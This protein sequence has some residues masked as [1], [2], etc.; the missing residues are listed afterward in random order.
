MRALNNYWK[1]ESIRLAFEYLIKCGL[2]K[3]RMYATYFEGN[4]EIPEDVESREIWKKYLNES[5]IVPSSMDDNFWRAADEGPCGASTEI[6]YDLIKDR[7]DVSNLVNKDDETLIEIWNIVFVEYNEK[8]DNNNVS[9]YN[10]LNKRF[11]DT[12]MGLQRIA[13]ILQNKTSIYTTDFYAKLIK[14]VEILSLNKEY[15]DIYDPLNEKINTMKAI[16]IFA[17]HMSY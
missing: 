14:Y 16:R 4:E 3:E 15:I 1:E 7:R 13:M 2:D 12:G 9:N 8:K 11:I 5:R 17:D 6:H 10:L